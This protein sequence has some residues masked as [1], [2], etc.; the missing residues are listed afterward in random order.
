MRRQLVCSSLLVTLLAAFPAMA[1]SATPPAAQPAPAAPEGQT[2]AMPL[3]AVTG[4]SGGVEAEAV[5]ALLVMA[6]GKI[7]G[8]RLVSP[9]QALRGQLPSGS[10]NLGGALKPA[11]KGQWQLSMKLVAPGGTTQTWDWNGAD[12]VA[13]VS[14]ACLRVTS[15]LKLSPKADDWKAIGAILRP[16][17]K[18]RGAWELELAARRSLWAGRWLEAA[19]R[20]VDVAKRD[21]S[22][23]DAWILLARTFRQAA[24][25]Q[26]WQ[27]WFFDGGEE[28]KLLT[29]R[30][31]EAAQVAVRRSPEDG[32]AWSELAMAYALNGAEVSLAEE[33]LDQAAKLPISPASLTAATALVRGDAASW[34]KATETADQD[35][36]II[37]LGAARALANED[38]AA[39][40]A[41]YQRALAL[42]PTSAAAF[43]GLARSLAAQ[44]RHAEA[45]LK[46]DELVKLRPAIGYWLKGSLHL[47]IGE[48]ERAQA[49][50]DAAAAAQPRSASL[51]YF[52][53]R[54]QLA[55]GEHEHALES[56]RAALYLDPQHGPCHLLIGSLYQDRLK[57]DRLARFHLEKA[58]DL[59]PEVKGAV[60]ARLA[61]LAN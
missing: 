50:F 16:P 58:A 7:D 14:N 61:K 48:H 11:G 31:L 15:P 32:E 12:P 17:A 21:P 45:Q 34:Q 60:A 41:L 38:P 2:A 57:Q 56:L 8:L 6:L 5:T 39:A 43:Y 44:Q 29:T 20:F 23:N 3:L 1:Q 26:R 30:H 40:E 10:W 27:P 22:R 46:A 37:V 53:A 47:A 52:Q 55:R 25:Q 9:A 24:E 35:V 28:G 33:A 42:D 51:T 49:A 13:G 36:G 54:A 18:E 59:M 19:N 4:I